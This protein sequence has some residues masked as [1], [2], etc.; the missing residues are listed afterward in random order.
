MKIGLLQ[1]EL[2]IPGS[3]SLK[4]KRRVVRSIKDRLHREHLVSVAEVGALSTWNVAALGI[5]IVSADG[6]YAHA[7]LD[8]IVRKLHSHPE[9]RLDNFLLDVVDVDQLR[10][11]S[12]DDDGSELWTPDERR[13]AEDL[14]TS[15]AP[16][17]Q[18]P[19]SPH[20][21]STKPQ[22]FPSDHR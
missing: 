6:G 5:S 20:P 1:V 22:P 14:L 7:V 12:L 2:N 17:L 15:D 16:S 4:D 9:A 21:A 13:D 10:A 11:G 3:M 8:N 18:S 19:N